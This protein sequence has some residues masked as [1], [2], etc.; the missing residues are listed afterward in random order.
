M[1]RV[2]LTIGLYQKTLQIKICFIYTITYL[3][4]K[5]N[6]KNLSLTTLVG[7]ISYENSPSMIGKVF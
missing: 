2:I 4:I 3:L 5:T 7:L 6:R 1:S